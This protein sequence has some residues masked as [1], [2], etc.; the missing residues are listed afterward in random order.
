MTESIFTGPG[1][2]LLAPE[3]FGVS[4]RQRERATTTSSWKAK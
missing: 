3:T 1:E 4:M 2:V